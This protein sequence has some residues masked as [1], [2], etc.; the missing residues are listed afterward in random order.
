M[1][2]VVEDEFVESVGLVVAAVGVVVAAAAVV[3]VVVAVAVT[4]DAVVAVVD[5][6]AQDLNLGWGLVVQGHHP[7]YFLA[8]V[9][10]SFVLVLQH[11]LM[12]C[13]PLSR[14]KRKRDEGK[15]K[16]GRKIE[17]AKRGQEA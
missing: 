5:V 6:V 10:A 2:A 1:V 15:M 4:A 11:S 7:T 3:V 17:E 16:R 9:P 12:N 13:K 14:E 8:G